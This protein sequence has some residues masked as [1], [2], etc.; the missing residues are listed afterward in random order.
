MRFSQFIVLFILCFTFVSC[1]DFLNGSK[2]KD[3]VIEL[4]GS[5]LNCLSGVPDTLMRYLNSAAEDKEIREG[6]ECMQEALNYFSVRTKGSKADGY[7]V[8]DVR[9]FFGKYFLKERNL[10]E[11]L[12]QEL[13]KIKSAIFGG[14]NET[15]TRSE[16]ARIN[17][18]INLLEAEMI[19]LK[20]HVS[21]LL[22]KRKNIVGWD[23]IDSA[24]GSL[25][26]SVRKLF[27]NS[28]L[29]RSDYG[30]D[31]ARTL[32]T[33][34]VNFLEQRESIKYFAFFESVKNILL[35]QRSELHGLRDWTFASD[36]MLSLYS[37]YLKYA[38][39]VNIEEL[40]S[41]KGVDTLSRIVNETIALIENCYQIKKTGRISFD[42]IDRMLDQAAL[43]YKI[44]GSIR[45]DSI[46]SMYKNLL[47]TVFDSVRHGDSRGFDS[48]E[49]QHLLSI[50]K[51]Y[52]LWRYEQ[53]FID[54]LISS[55]SLYTR[56]QLTK[57]YENYRTNNKN[58][59]ENDP[60]SNRLLLNKNSEIKYL[61]SNV[62]PI[63]FN[64]NARVRLSKFEK[65]HTMNW[66]GL[67]KMNIIRTAHRLFQFGYGNNALTDIMKS[68]ITRQKFASFFEHFKMIGEDLN[69]ID[70]NGVSP[71][72]RSFN[73]ANFFMP[74]GNGDEEMSY[75]ETYEYLSFLLTE[76]ISGAA[77]FE[78]ALNQNECFVKEKNKN[79][80]KFI[81]EA[82]LKLTLKAQFSSL[83]TNIPEHVSFIKSLSEQD[84]D[85]YFSA[86]LSAA[87]D[88]NNTKVGLIAPSDVLVMIMLIHYCESLFVRY[89]ADFSETLSLK[90]LEVASDRFMSFIREFS[91]VKRDSFVRNLFLYIAYNGKRPDGW[92][93]TGF[94]IKKLAGKLGVIDR[95]QL[96]RVLAS[97][98]NELK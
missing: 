11:T 47:L 78:I 90:E 17:V 16:I 31:D 26:S 85:N 60:I 19:E 54:T 53:N 95:T 74:S 30:I 25:K 81:N 43:E 91:P 46:K 62:N 3:A 52:N 12:V 35:G 9:Q 61:I 82:C 48:L 87:K 49:R 40:N 32:V 4:E 29:V 24:I 70:A 88:T 38:Y 44:F 65:N 23:E 64:E 51:E 68:T 84:W 41:L 79:D 93:L 96:F 89:D 97:L 56:N 98:K 14:S 83:F 76:G 45:T 8:E 86:L 6:S 13:M 77:D 42:D 39:K 94:E 10:S 71:A 22:F 28:D 5:S 59:S 37:L 72:K 1:S 55:S 36:D 50:R 92:D 69:I 67:T 34:L 33:E 15:I 2:D 21:L 80:V 66:A 63:T 18:F 7:T 58:I 75:F 73:E 57:L 27:I 20:P